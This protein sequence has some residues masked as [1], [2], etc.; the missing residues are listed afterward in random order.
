M[1]DSILILCLWIP[2][3]ILFVCAVTA[4][5]S[6]K[7]ALELLGSVPHIY[8]YLCFVNFFL[9]LRYTVLLCEELI[10]ISLFFCMELQ[11]PNVSMIIT[12]YWMP[13]M[14]GYELL[15]KVKVTQSL[16]LPGTEC[17]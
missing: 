12:D 9:G 15:K 17:M 2:V 16:T 14:T 8:I 7:R 3:L 4:V 5:D 10:H 6:G 13:E 11:E 1:F